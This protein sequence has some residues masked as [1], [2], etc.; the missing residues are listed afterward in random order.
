MLVTVNCWWIVSPSTFMFR[1]AGV[2]GTNQPGNFPQCWSNILYLH[3]T[4]FCSFYWLLWR[5]LHQ[6]QSCA[7]EILLFAIG[8]KKQWFRWLEKCQTLD[9]IIS[10][11]DYFCIFKYIYCQK[12]TSYY[13]LI[14]YIWLFFICDI[15]RISFRQVLLCGTFYNTVVQLGSWTR[16]NHRWVYLLWFISGYWLQF[17]TQVKQSVTAWETDHSLLITQAILFLSNSHHHVQFTVRYT[18]YVEFQHMLEP[19]NGH[20]EADSNKLLFFITGDI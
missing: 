20:I 15:S 14:T 13:L 7:F 4:T 1:P 5:L 8:W 17:V 2:P 6:S 10:E 9:P 16:S 19:T 12:M 18:Q 11:A 3:S